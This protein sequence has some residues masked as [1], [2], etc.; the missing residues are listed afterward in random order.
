VQ[1]ALQLLEHCGLDVPTGTPASTAWFESLVAS[2]VDLS[3]RDALTGVAN[4]RAFDLALAR[5]ADRVARHGEAALLLMLDIDHFKRVNDTHGHGA[6]D[7]V[8][9]AVAA[10]LR[11]C[12]RPMDLVA[13]TGGEEFAIV[14]PNCPAAF[15]EAVA[16]RVRRRI[17]ATPVDVAPGTRLS[18]TASVGGAFAP[19]WVRS[20]ATLWVERADQQLFLAKGRGRNLVCLESSASPLVTAE[21]RR[22]LFDAFQLQ[23]P[24]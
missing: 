18:V 11:D 14:L 3:S 24:E 15:G 13:R 12:V 5:E 7:L 21:E 23:D 4:R 8:L 20:S 22:M 2:L 16:E 19:P 1:R 17:E 10:A 6:G 9:K